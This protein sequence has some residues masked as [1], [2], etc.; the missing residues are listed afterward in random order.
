MIDLSEHVLIC[1]ASSGVGRELA[2]TYAGKC[3]LTLSSRRVDRLLTISD[4]HKSIQAI[5][6]DFSQLS[7][8]DKLVETAVELNGKL[9]KVFYVAGEQNIKPHK[10]LNVDDLSRLMN[11][12]L[13]SPMRLGS[14]F[15]QNKFSNESSVYGVIS[16]I[17]GISP[18]P[19]I[20]A[21]ST[22]KA[23]LNSFVSGLAKE[24]T[25]G[26]RVFAVAPSWLDTEMTQ[27]FKV[28]YSDRFKEEFAKKSPLGL[29]TISQ[30][31][32]SLVW[33]SSDKATYVNGAVLKL[34]GGLI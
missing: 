30:V 25:C 34:D 27:K 4:A 13:I 29:G 10:K 1:G 23:G 20:V 19:G 5:Q 18:E 22:T 12:N 11:V 14:L 26:R 8:M 17:A 21:Y 3:K 16:S 2:L 32:D 15:L 6:S 33:L 28:I 7:E 31:V 9:D 24:T